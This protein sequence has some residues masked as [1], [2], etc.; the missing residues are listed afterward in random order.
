LKK[1][2]LVKD[3]V[4]EADSG[5]Y[6]VVK[7]LGLTGATARVY[8]V[9]RKQDSR[10]FA[11]KLMQSGLSPEM[12][13]HFRD[14]MVNLQRLRAA[15]EKSGT[16]HIPRIIESSDLQQ[17]KT[18][19]L[20]RLLGNPFIIMDF[21]EGTD[22][23]TLLMDKTV[24]NEAEAL[25]ISKQF[26]EVLVVIHGEGL[27]YTDMKM[28]NLFWNGKTGH[29]TVIDW[30][31]IAEDRLEND[32][33]K[34]RLR[35]AAYLFQA[36]T[37]IPIELDIQGTGVVNQKYRRWENFKNLSQG[38]R[39]FLIK[40]FH[41]DPASRHG[42]GGIP[43]HCTKEF[44]KELEIH[45]ARFKL[46]T[47]DLYEKGK[48]ALDYRQWQ[49]AWQY[50]DLADR[51]WDIEANPGQFAQL[52]KDLE[53]AKGEAKKLGRS[54][55]FSGQ[56]GYNSELYPEALEDFEKA[57][58]D[59]PYDEEAR[60]FAILTRCAL[61]VGE[62][63][64][65]KFKDTLEDCVRALLKEHLDL[66]EDTLQRLPVEMQEKS[67]VA[68]LK[69]E[70]KIRG[71]VQK[72]QRLLKEN[73]LE[74]AQTFFPGVNLQRDRILYIE[75][76]EENVGSL[77]LLYQNV[78]ELKKLYEEGNAYFAEE[79][80][81]EAAWVFW[82]ARELSQ[83]SPWAN[84]KYQSAASFD[85]IKKLLE[86]GSLERAMEECQR[87]SSRFGHEPKYGSL[88]NQVID[89]RCE[90]LRVLSDNAYEAK[91]YRSA[92]EYIQEY[93]KWK[94]EEEAAK[95][96]LEDIRKERASGYQEKIR[97]L[98][99]ALRKDASPEACEQTIRYVEEQGYNRFSE[100]RQFIERT[101]EL[102]E[103]ISILSEELDD[104]EASGDLAAQLKVLNKAQTKN[105]R[106]RQGDPQKLKTSIKPKIL[107]S[108]IDKI[109]THLKHCQPKEALQLCEN[110]LQTGLPK[111]RQ[112]IIHQSIETAHKLTGTLNA[113]EH[114]KAQK[115]L[116]SPNDE[117]AELVRLRLERD[118]L[119]ALQQMKQVVPDL[120]APEDVK[121]YEKK[122]ETFFQDLGTCLSASSRKGNSLLAKRDFAGC[123]KISLKIEETLVIFKEFTGSTASEVEKW[124]TWN[125][126]FNHLAA[127]LEQEPSNI[128]WTGDYQRMIEKLMDIIKDTRLK[129]IISHVK[130]IPLE[131]METL[132]KEWGKLASLKEESPAAFW[133][134]QFL[135]R[136]LKMIQTWKAVDEDPEHAEEVI[137]RY[138]DSS[139]RKPYEYPLETIKEV[140]K[141]FS[142]QEQLDNEPGLNPGKLEENLQQA[143]ELHHRLQ[144]FAQLVGKQTDKR[145]QN[146]ISM[147]HQRILEK[148]ENSIKECSANL[149]ELLKRLI[150]TGEDHI[151]RLKL[152]N[153]T[154]QEIE[155]LGNTSQEDADKFEKRLNDLLEKLLEVSK[156]NPQSENLN[157]LFELQRRV[158]DGY[159]N[160]KNVDVNGY[161]QQ[162][163][164]ESDFNDVIPDYKK[165]HENMLY[166]L[167]KLNQVKEKNHEE[168]FKSL[169]ELR[170]E[171]GEFPELNAAMEEIRQEIL[172][173]KNRETF[174]RL[175]E[176]FRGAWREEEWQ[177][178]AETI[179][180]IDPLLLQ[181]SDQAK[182]TKIKSEIKNQLIIRGTLDREDVVKFL[183]Y[184]E[185]EPAETWLKALQWNV[186]EKKGVLKPGTKTLE[187]IRNG[188]IHW[189]KQRELNFKSLLALRRIKLFLQMIDHLNPGTKRKHRGKP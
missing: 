102:K 60:L 37:G 9:K 125:Q 165:L 138:F 90:Q 115:T 33:P 186:R 74:E 1:E 134:H 48:Q 58:R 59:D 66:A 173:E 97:Q 21:A 72:G 4:I 155:K 44:L 154:R 153:E 185:N 34:D 181:E 19:Q 151:T 42:H 64:F 146:H 178:L 164:Q 81:H 73:R 83:G 13:K 130:I 135:E 124:E 168:R 11:L 85:A 91:D 143:R 5:D 67:A 161:L 8:L 137:A 189:L 176:E 32:A 75:P 86:K 149:E 50:L 179:E 126:E 25:E 23:H 110:V 104:A 57:M 117:N 121:E 122:Q 148:K 3:S 123:K 17:P 157:R 95:V 158:C 187:N 180:N 99:I 106:L 167:E 47:I 12:I 36:V 18:Q 63:T 94:P 177:K 61:D 15:E 68:A 166:K 147:L 140:G 65:L 159:P 183:A 160:E 38:T 136:Q 78:E 51:R 52:Q 80:F 172:R 35:A 133:L 129:K 62:E 113:L 7:R 171:F 54:A 31:V 10:L 6:C 127:W 184:G 108:N 162:W 88:K 156:P 150:D 105:W 26:A 20:L 92:E 28:D 45:A 170:G 41:P 46:S 174:K 16:S 89:A 163:E 119:L 30:N 107:Q 24:L 182:Y 76:L 152:E 120:E 98:E 39:T 79:R 188:E 112:T 53:K 139:E 128:D 103:A 71:A 111:K 144:E 131:K 27:T 109:R 100:G 114:I 40:A 55:F 96:K 70:I 145:L 116:F 49:E 22:L 101:G 77:T 84:K 93:L 82:K 87:V 175:C 118:Y 132:Q 141:F 169:L 43:L 56:G 14:E 2:L 29:L 142:L 69:A